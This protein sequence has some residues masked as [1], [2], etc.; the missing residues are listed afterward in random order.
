MITIVLIIAVAIIAVLAAYG[1]WK[2]NKRIDYE[3]QCKLK[4]YKFLCEVIDKV[5]SVTDHAERISSL[6]NSTNDRIKILTS[7]LDDIDAQYDYLHDRLL[8]HCHAYNVENNTLYIQNP[9]RIDNTK[10]PKA[11]EKNE[12]GSLEI[13]TM[14]TVF[15]I[16]LK[17]IGAVDWSWVLVTAPLWG[18]LAILYIVYIIYMT[19]Q[20]FKRK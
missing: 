11:I 12:E 19:Y 9:L 4:D 10:E 20:L 2:T 13:P 17:L 16:I 1:W 3:I 5:N 18:T 6:L 15:F 14:L 8:T 7:R